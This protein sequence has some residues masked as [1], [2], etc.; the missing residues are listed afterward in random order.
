MRS[1][2]DR[3]ALLLSLVAVIAAYLV[4]DRVFG[5]VPHV[6]DEMAYVWQAQVLAQGRLTLP[7]PPDP[8]SLMVPFVVDYHGQRFGKYPLGWPMALAL[9]LL[10]HARDWVNPILA[11][12][13]LWLTYRLGK[14]LFDE[15]IALLAALL[16]LTSPFFLM[17]SGS[18][19][20]HPWC[21]FLSLAFVLAWLDTFRPE[22]P[23]AQKEKPLVG[24]VFQQ[25]APKWLT[26][27][28]AGLSL[29]ALA[30]TRALTA[31]G[32][33]LPFFVHGV[34]LL[35][36]GDRS[37][38]RRV[39]TI[40]SLAVLVA[41]LI[42]L[43]QF[44]VTGNPILNPYTLWW[45]YDKVGFGPGIGSEP[46]GHDL[47]WAWYNLDTSLKVGWGDFF[48]WGHVSWLFL[49]FGLWSLG[50]AAPKWLVA[51]VFPSLLFVY[52]A[53]WIGSDLYGPRYYFEGFYSLS[54]VSAAGI[55]WLAERVFRSGRWR[56][57]MQIATFSLGAILI[58]YNLTV[59]LPQRLEGMMDLYGIS[60]S[61]LAPFETSEARSLTPALVIVH[62]QKEWT[63]YGG[64][65][66][67]E[68]AELTSPF[69]FALSQG[70]IL[71]RTLANDFPG[72]RVIYYYTDQ[73]DVLY[74][75]P[76]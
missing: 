51:L 63:E 31:L 4:A 72:R 68:N 47:H 12:L 23:P 55:F 27:S 38:R 53:Y 7:S 59:Y 71:D 10:L 34:I 64:L 19:L 44:T 30:W 32:V 26:V 6:E 37:T 46:S 61:M 14:K 3:V 13:A 2:A 15:R 65:L 70:D 1:P 35:V 58:G 11:G 75:S 54:L 24:F 43:W 20:A 36:R 49:P 66:E 45:P 22:R 62:Y 69:I 16:T 74:A 5:R 41:A 57:W 33:G 29:G 8:T 39:L 50:R 28:V 40:G 73:P 60:R 21:L 48:G 52:M 42:P 9:G 67:L 56:R 17:I 76:R 18:L 25:S